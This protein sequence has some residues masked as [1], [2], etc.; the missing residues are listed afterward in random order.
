MKIQFGNFRRIYYQYCQSR[1]YDLS[2]VGFSVYSDLSIFDK[3]MPN[4]VKQPL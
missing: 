4:S 3:D 1:N 2:R